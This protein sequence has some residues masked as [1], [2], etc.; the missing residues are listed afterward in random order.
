MNYSAMIDEYT[1]TEAMLR[2]R[3]T[4]LRQQMKLLPLPEQDQ[5]KRRLYLLQEEM[6]DVAL[7]RLE[8]VRRQREE[9]VV[10]C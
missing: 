9:E 10:L 4:A 5:I 8:L 6:Y 1:L 7:V 2:E 3:V